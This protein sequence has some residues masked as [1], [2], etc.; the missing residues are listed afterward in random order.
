MTRFGDVLRGAADR[1][2][3]TPAR[4]SPVDSPTE[5]LPTVPAPR[6]GGAGTHRAAGRREADDTEQSPESPDWQPRATVRRRRRRAK[7][8]RLLEWPV[9]VGMALLVALV[10]RTFVLQSFYIP[11]GSMFDTL[12]INNRVVVNKLSYHLHP[13]HRGDVVVFNRPKNVKISDKDLIKRVIGLPGD[14]MSGHDGSVYVGSR[15]LSEPYVKAS[16][17]GTGDF[18]PITVP[19][20]DIFVM[21]DNRCNSYDSRFFGP[22][23]QSLVVGR[24]FL[25]IWPLD[26][27]GA[28]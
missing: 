14:V 25:L 17:H 3:P 24:A 4:W 8:R 26:R 1:P 9:L 6:G 5:R 11:S 13:I 28:L 10:V 21:G 20:H 12:K 15:R 19:A 23:P 27:F 22:I 16:C 2:I 18:A 7:R